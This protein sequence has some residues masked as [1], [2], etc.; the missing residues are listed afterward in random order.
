MTTITQIDGLYPFRS[1]VKLIVF[2]RNAA[3]PF[4]CVV[5]NRVTGRS[6]RRTVIGTIMG[7]AQEDCILRDCDPES[8]FLQVDELA[9][10]LLRI[11]ATIWDKLLILES[12]FTA[13][14]IS[15]Q[16]DLLDLLNTFEDKL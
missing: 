10:N 14:T 3:G 6:E 9:Q 5:S 16:A 1:N 12:S 13:L 8:Y 11:I 2:T 4:S 15:K 7:T